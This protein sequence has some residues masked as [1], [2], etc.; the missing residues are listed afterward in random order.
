MVAYRAGR[1]PRYVVIC[2]VTLRATPLDLPL[3]RILSP[4]S[5]G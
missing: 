4:S 1:V 2:P 3:L 5:M